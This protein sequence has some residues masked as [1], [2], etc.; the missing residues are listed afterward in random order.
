M[1]HKNSKSV[2]VL[3]TQ[4]CTTLSKSKDCSPPGSSVHGILQARILEWVSMPFSRGSSQPRDWTQVSH[5]ADRFFT[6]WAIQNTGKFGKINFFRTLET[7]KST[8]ELTK[9]HLLKKTNCLSWEQTLWHL[10][11]SI[12]LSIFLALWQLEKQQL[13]KCSSCDIQQSLRVRW[14]GNWAWNCP[15][16]HFQKSVTIWPKWHLPRKGPLSAVVLFDL[17][18]SS[19][20]GN[21]LN[22]NMF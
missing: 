16:H 15:S 7:T 2:C 21:S 13:Y 17:I 10:I 14:E 12:S 19:L 22:S 8:L 11:Y 1:V 5:I 20:S 9:K 18:Q 3:I 6:M 4:S